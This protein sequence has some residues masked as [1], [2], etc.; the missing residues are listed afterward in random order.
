MKETELAKHI[1][2]WLEGWTIYQEVQIHSFGRTADIVAVKKPIIWIIECKTSL[3]LSLLEQAYKW[4]NYANYIS[5]ATVSAKNSKGRNAAMIFLKQNG[6]GLITLHKNG[7]IYENISPLLNRKI[8][9]LM[10]NT[11]ND[12]HKT[13]APAGNA[14]GKRWTPYQQTVINI[15]KIVKR[16][17][18]IS[19]KELM[20]EIKHHYSTRS[21]A[22]SSISKYLRMGI[23]EGI[24]LKKDG[25]HLKLFPSSSSKKEK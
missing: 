19:L 5:V 12:N 8:L 17:P 6:I 20:N 16:K 21:S 2:D 3:S 4:K 1:I 11:L 22:I 24:V 15:R 10:K 14:I 9:S 7:H 18:G 25:K 23:I 13:F